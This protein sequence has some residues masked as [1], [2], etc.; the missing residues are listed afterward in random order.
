MILLVLYMKRNIILHFL[1]KRNATVNR[2]DLQLSA[3]KEM[4]C[5]SLILS[6]EAEEIVCI[7]FCVSVSFL[8]ALHSNTTRPCLGP[9]LRPRRNN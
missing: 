5:I 8:K 6:S 3:D 1:T 2:L 7:V 4:L 9:S